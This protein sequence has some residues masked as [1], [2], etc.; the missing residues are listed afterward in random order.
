[1]VYK[2]VQINQY[3][4]IK[5]SNNLFKATLPGKKTVYRVW[6]NDS[7]QPFCDIISFDNEKLEV[8]K[9]TEVWTIASDEKLTVTPQKI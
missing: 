5:F 4:K 6:T 2:L 7:E 9:P 1:M 8:G 3:S